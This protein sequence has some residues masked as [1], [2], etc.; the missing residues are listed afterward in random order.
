M[1]ATLV[2]DPGVRCR[3]D[4]FGNILIEVDGINAAG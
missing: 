4:D 1:D 2:V 3:V